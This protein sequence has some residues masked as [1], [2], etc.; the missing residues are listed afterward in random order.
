[1]VSFCEDENDK[2]PRVVVVAIYDDDDE[3]E[4]EAIDLARK[5]CSRR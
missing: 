1:M 2:D 5:L 4:D 3:E